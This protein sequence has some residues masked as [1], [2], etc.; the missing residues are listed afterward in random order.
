MAQSVLARLFGR[1]FV[2]SVGAGFLLAAGASRA[3]IPSTVFSGTDY[4]MT[5]SG[6]ATYV[7]GNQELTFSGLRIGN[8]S[9]NGSLFSPTA[10]PAGGPQSS[11][12]PP[13]PDGGYSG[14]ADTVVNRLQ[15]VDPTALSI[16]PV[17]P[18]IDPNTG[19][20]IPE[21]GQA[22]PI[23]IVGLSL[24][25]ADILPIQNG[26]YRAYAGLEKYYR[27]PAGTGTP[28]LGNMFIRDAVGDGGKTW[29]S[30]FTINAHA[31]LVPLGSGL[32]D[33]SSDFVRTV[34]TNLELDPSLPAGFEPVVDELYPCRY[35]SISMMCLRFVKDNF[36]AEREPW[37]ANP[38][39]GLEG[40]NL[41]PYEL[42]PN[43]YAENNFYLT[44]IVTHDAGDGTIHVVTPAV[45]GPLPIFGAT[46]AYS[47]ARRLRARTRVVRKEA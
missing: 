17:N 3:A 47:F 41:V 37:S 6:G 22:T 26:Q 16:N 7:Y 9:V 21:I 46:A 5:P 35:N 38:V 36:I 31:F 19:Q 27:S 14:F 11:P 12:T 2:G 23:E 45:P 28:S 32:D 25:G 33:T 1:A 40:E 44:G 42:S 43:N 34:L 29:D 15:N 30:K 24:K 10:P 18:K 13:N 39:G 4:L 20:Q 8:P